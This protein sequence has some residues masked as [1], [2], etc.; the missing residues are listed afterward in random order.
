MNWRSA[1]A[2]FKKSADLI[3]AGVALVCVVRA[4]NPDPS[5][6]RDRPLLELN[7]RKFGYDTSSATR[8]LRKFVDFTDSGHLAVAW[9]TFDDPTLAD[10]TGPLT[11]RPAHL[12]VL[13]LNAT[14]GQKVG[15]QT[16]STPSTPV[17]FLAARD[18]KFVT[19]TG[20]VLR[21]FSPSF[22]V[23]RE[24]ALPNDHAC[25][26]QFSGNNQW[27]IPRW[28]ISPSRRS[29]LL[30]VPSGKGYE[31]KLL[32]LET[33]AVLA[34]WAENLRIENISDHWLVAPCGQKQAVCIRR[35][36]QP[37]RPFQATSV[38]NDSRLQPIGFAN[39]NTLV[40]GW[41]KLAVTTVD[42]EQLFHVE[43]PKKLSIEAPV[44]SSGGNRFAVIED[45]ERGLTNKTLDMDAFAS[46]DRAVVYSIPDHG[47]IFAIK[48]KGTSPWPPWEN[49][50][51]ELALS[52][53]G[54][55]LAVVTG[56]TLKVYRLP[57]GTLA[58]RRE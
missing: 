13:V 52:P 57:D 11:A 24:L 30:S 14:T 22:E 9:L 17:R 41:N 42:G 10:R 43:L 32:D 26:S 21:L 46:N 29:L 20:N 35:I 54:G 25:L 4:Q 15:M 38:D 3:V 50:V 58:P 40:M 51:N 23:I 5:L 27:G 1:K 18:G 49:H 8:R 45:R 7:L 48:I 53:D 55:L 33:L 6:S 37:W 28:G 19:C 2:K 47:A 31:N 44:T 39:D 56:A 16:W 34:T 12:H 36:D